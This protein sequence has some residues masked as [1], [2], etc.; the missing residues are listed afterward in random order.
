M[1]TLL[2]VWRARDFRVAVALFCVAAVTGMVYV[3]TWGS[4]PHF[5]QELFG[6]SALFACGRGFVN[7]VEGDCPALDDFLHPPMHTWEPPPVDKFDCAALPERLETQPFTAFQQRQMYLLAAVAAVWWLFGVAWSALAPLYGL[8]YGASAAALYGI[9]RQGVSRALAALCTLA[10]VFSPIQLNNLVR[11]RD[12]AKAPFLLGIILVMAWLVRRGGTRHRVLFG[13]LAAGLLI[14]LGS[15]FR[16]DTL[17]CLPAFAVLLALFVEG[18]PW[19]RPFTRAAALLLCIGLAA[20]LLLPF[21]YGLEAGG[22]YHHF[23]LGLND[24]YDGKLGVGGAPYQIGHRYLDREAMAILQAFSAYVHGEPRQYAFE[25][26]A[27]Q[28][29]GREYFW[30]VVTTFPADLVLRAYAAVLRVVDELHAS[31][32]WPAPRG[33]E[34]VFVQD[35]F[36]LRAAALYW[37]LRFA[38]YAVLA[39]LALLA[40]RRL[41]WGFGAL[42]LLL[43]FC[44]YTAIQFASRH[45]FH[46]EFIA[47]WA[48]VFTAYAVSLGLWTLRTR[49]AR[50]HW[51]GRAR[52]SLSMMRHWRL[53]PALRRVVVFGVATAVLLAVPLWGLRVVQAHQVRALLDRY[54]SA[55]MVAADTT[56][57]PMEDDKVLVRCAD[58]PGSGVRDW[59]AP[60]FEFAFLAAEF[61]TRGGA[62]PVTVRYRGGVFDLDFTWQTT[63]PQTDA[64]LA[65]LFFPVY[66]ARWSDAEKDWTY[67]DGLELAAADADRLV[68]VRRVERPERFDLLLTAVLPPDWRAGPAWQRIIR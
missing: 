28:E 54:A 14:G 8:L 12:Y 13:G 2:S 55:E 41:R 59:D 65:R 34:N 33:V 11:L 35:L 3:S 60:R 58:L 4:T 52:R 36:Y 1:R 6:P 51:L 27:Y 43:F 7:P 61:D 47:L 50:R 48:A 62:A 21:L 42:F 66:F 57:V 25:T 30:H 19:R 23:L 64:G 29:I 53:P 49:D 9:F 39:G 22:S 63:V 18:A 10:L 46:L 68:R 17:I 37:P 15:G 31:L 20:L 38:R 5:Y 40:A 16:M 26:L 32:A 56:P 45:A 44:G 67:F 24:L